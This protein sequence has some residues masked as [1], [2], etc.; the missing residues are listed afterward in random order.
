MPSRK[1]N[2]LFAIIIVFALLIAS[3][4]SNAAPTPPIS[5]NPPEPSTSTPPTENEQPTHAFMGVFYSDAVPRALRRQVENS[6]IPFSASMN[7]DVAKPGNNGVEFQWIYALVAP[8][9]TIQ[10]G[11]TSDELRSI[12]TEGG[13]SLL[14]AESTMKAF[15]VSWGEPVGG[16]V[17]S[18]AE[19]QL[20]E[21]A[22]TESA[23]AIIPFESI[24]PKWKVLT[25]DGQSPIRKKFD[26]TNYPLIVDFSLEPAVFVDASSWALSNYDSGR[27][28][29]VIMTGVTA[30]V[31]ATALTM[32]LKGSTYPGEK[33]RDVFREADIM[34]VSNEIPFFTGCPYPKPDPGALVFCSDPKYMDLITDIGTDVIEL[35]G[36]HFADYGRQAMYETLD[37]Y[38]A[39]N[40]PY[41]GGGRDL[42]DSLKP[43]LFEVSGNKVAFIGCNRPDVGRFPTATDFQPGAAPCD[44]AYLEQKIAEL[45]S[46][47]YVVVSTFQWNE[48]YDSRPNPQQVNEFR[49]M[50]DSG[51]SIVSG[52]QA[53]Y[54]QM[55]EFYESAFIH[56]GLGNLFFDQMGDQD[57]MPPGIRREFFDRYAIYDGKLVSVELIT[58]LLEDYSR[59]R[60]MSNEERAGFLQEYFYYS[61]W[62]DLTPTPTPIVTP[63]MTP[64][65]IP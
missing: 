53:H 18:V 61:G 49:L 44:F 54:A 55:M 48:S 64:L 32:E 35:T 46:L 17:R 3:C 27:L 6:D 39:N 38:R 11:V 15:T 50:A 16:S 13:I 2:R 12:W 60:L 21:R 52:S 58:A 22:W 33:V 59:P 51:A 29:T 8:F 43:A 37:I 28:T 34:H 56:Y 9:P 45:R 62:T 57:W 5:N 31:R 26:V 47:G 4:I 20:L 10:D 25:V 40:I 36:N 30:L 65:S 1:S 24:E 23:W 42:Q 63:T 14:M 41:F 19:D 7:L